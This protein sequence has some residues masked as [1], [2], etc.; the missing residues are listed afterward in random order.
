MARQ[1]LITYPFHD[2]PL[3]PELITIDGVVV[4]MVTKVISMGFLIEPGSP[5][6]TKAM[7]ALDGDGGDLGVDLSPEQ[8]QLM[9]FLWKNGWECEVDSGVSGL[10]P[11]LTFTPKAPG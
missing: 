5:G 2:R 11:Y 8:A 6:L 7:V 10:A 3:V 4:A 9:A 1:A